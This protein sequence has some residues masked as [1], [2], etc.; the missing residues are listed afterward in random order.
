MARDLEARRAQHRSVREAVSIAHSDTWLATLAASSAAM[1]A[2]GSLATTDFRGF[3]HFGVIGGLG[4]I[5]CWCATFITLPAILVVSER[6][7]P[8]FSDPNSARS[9]ARGFYGLIF[10]WI[11]DRVPRLIVVVALLIGAASAWLPVRCAS[12]DPMEYNLSNISAGRKGRSPARQLSVRVDRVVG[13]M[14]QDGMAVMVDRIDQVAQLEMALMHRREVA[15]AGQKPFDRVVSLFSLLPDRQLEKVALIEEVLDRIHRARAKGAIDDRQWIDIEP[16]LPKGRLMPLTIADLR[17]NMARP[18]TARDGTRG[19]IVYIVPADGRSIWDGHYLDQWAAS[20]REV[21]LPGGETI[22]GSGSAVVWSDML[23]AVRE[24]SPKAIFASLG[25]ALVV[26]VLAFRLRRES[27]MVL[28]TMLLGVASR[29]GAGG[30]P[31]P[32]CT[33]HKASFVPIMPGRADSGLRI[34]RSP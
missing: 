19:R 8:M 9:R 20:Y 27:W 1:V 22:V 13:R 16:H 4:M 11:S 33:T 3:K 28:G 21:T 31:G 10:A 30:A 17:V 12:S 14:G 7:S 15:P 6:L 32:R 24:D 2:Y 25:G 23:R 29:T 18:F 26:V 5:L 34:A